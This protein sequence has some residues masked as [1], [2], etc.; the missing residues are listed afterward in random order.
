MIFEILTNTFNNLTNI[1]PFL[2]IFFSIILILGFYKI[3]EFFLELKPIGNIFSNISD[4]DYLKIF[5]GINF[6]LIFSFPII[7]FQLFS[8]IIINLSAIVIFTIGLIYFLRKILNIKNLKGRLENFSLK[9]NINKSYFDEKFFIFFLFGFFLLS[10]APTTQSDALGYHMFVGKSILENGVFPFSLLH[11]HSFL[12]GSGEILIA[13]GLFFGSDQFSSLIQF[14]GLLGLIGICK[15]FSRNNYFILLLLIATPVLLFLGS[16]PKPQLF[17]ACSNA[18]ILSIYLYGYKTK[19]VD[20]TQLILK[21]FITILILISS[22]NGKFSFL[23]SSSLIIILIF[24]DSIKEK[25]FH[26]F[27]ISIILSVLIFYFP[28][29]YWKYINFGGNFY[30]YLIYLLYIN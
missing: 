12:A 26:L 23:L 15:K 8:K 28:V 20:Q 3:G 18:I 2:S 11:L 17:F 22:I 7:I 30:N 13:L 1:Y 19:S 24:I 4:L 29:I 21:Y 5:F 27:F 14:S 6:F 16:S 9:K 10:L 25:K